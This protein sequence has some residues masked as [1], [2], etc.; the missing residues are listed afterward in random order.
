MYHNLV[1]KRKP[2]EPRENKKKLCNFE[3]AIL[4]LKMKL[5]EL[6]N[7]LQNEK[8][9]DNDL[10]EQLELG[11]SLTQ[12]SAVLSSAETL[13]TKKVLGKRSLKEIFEKHNLNIG[14][15][16]FSITVTDKCVIV[17]DGKAT[18]RKR[19]EY[20]YLTEKFDY[21]VIKTKS[22]SRLK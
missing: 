4:W 11:W 19:I 10:M 2:E 7:E 18:A 16:I 9:L 17:M 12:K 13:F 22:P 21:I 6:G 1:E 5:K 15:Y 20:D 14:N 8:K 3:L